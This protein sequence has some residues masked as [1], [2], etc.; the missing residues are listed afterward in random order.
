MSARDH[1]RRGDDGRA[2]VV[3]A[4]GPAVSDGVAAVAERARG[5]TTEG[6]AADARR[7]ELVS[8]VLPCLNEEGGVGATVAEAFRGLERAGVPGEV[9]VVDNGSTDRSVELAEAAGARVV[10]EGARG[11][12]AA[13]LA[14]LAAARGDV[15]VMADADQTYDLE[16]LGELLAPLRT[17]VD[18]VV[19]SRLQGAIGKGAMPGLHRY[20]G[21]PVLTRVLRLLTSTRLSDSQSGYRAFWREPVVGLGLRARG[22]EYAS[23]MLLKAGR[24]GLALAEV[25]TD[26]RPRVGESKLNTFGDGWRH[27]QMLL[28]LSPHLS[29][30][31]P[32]LVAALVGLVLC[33]VPVLAPA[34][35]LFFSVRWLPVFI[36]PMLLILGAQGLFLG[37]LAAHRSALTPVAF[38]RRFGLDFLDRPDAVNRLLGAFLLLA[39]LGVLLDAVLL[40]AWLADRSSDRLVGMAGLAQAL[41]VV[42]V[43]GIVTVFAADYSRE[44]LGW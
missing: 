37:A 39:L 23:E 41:I 29:L 44:S 12:G 2:G 26:Y 31:V 28:L 17:G 42:G 10:H 33:F 36:G 13:H 7:I 20:V 3:G 34:G 24:A 38:R 35:L 27:I 5:A 1:R 25:P 19:A 6:R 43:S 32:G 15:V 21:T 4:E 14:G 22:M 40:V 11:Y 30:I 9:V 18:M 8:V 16:N